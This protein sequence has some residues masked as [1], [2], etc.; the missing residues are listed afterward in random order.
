MKDT[1]ETRDPVPVPPETRD[2]S[3]V[4]RSGCEE[5]G[6]QPRADA[7]ALRQ[8]WDAAIQAWPAVPVAEGAQRRPDASTWSPVEYAAHARDMIRLLGIR[9]SSM[10][11][12]YDPEFTNWDGDVANVVRRDW[13]TDARALAEDLARAGREVAAVLDTLT[14]PMLERR[15]HRGDG[16]PFSVLSLW[17]YTDHDV[18]HHLWDISS[19]SAA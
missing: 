6:W 17:Q 14:A 9:L 16:M 8:A 18:E 2:W 13:S 4:L 1:E 11:A 15:G 10:L 3:F 12:E 5:C 19:R 7:A